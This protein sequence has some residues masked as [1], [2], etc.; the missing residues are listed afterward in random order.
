MG[1][2]PVNIIRVASHS[3]CS[4]TTLDQKPGIG[5][6]DCKIPF[7]PHC[8]DPRDML[9]MQH[10]ADQQFLTALQDA[11]RRAY[12]SLVLVEALRGRV[13]AHAHIDAL[14]VGAAIA[15]VEPHEI[16]VLPSPLCG[17]K[18][19][20][21]LVDE[22]QPRHVVHRQ[23]FG[24]RSRR[25]PPQLGERRFNAAGECVA[26][27]PLV[28]AMGA[29]YAIAGRECRAEPPFELAFPGGPPGTRAR[30]CMVEGCGHDAAVSG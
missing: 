23:P 10:R 5:E 17:L 24:D 15:I 20:G 16:N 22:G 25:M 9:Q 26:H 30:Q 13:S 8:V 7:N 21:D 19:C 6:R 18:R 4:V 2:I 11:A 27:P 14:Q 1:S 12:A 29:R 3:S 28:N